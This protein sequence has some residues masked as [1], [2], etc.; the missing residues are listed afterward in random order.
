MEGRQMTANNK[1]FV[2]NPVEVDEE[3][4]IS[5]LEDLRTV[6]NDT[7]RPLLKNSPHYAGLKTHEEFAAAEMA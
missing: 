2:T 3:L 7:V 4:F 5:V 6:D 1:I